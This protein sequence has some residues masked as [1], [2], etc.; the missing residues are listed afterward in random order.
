[1]PD[2]APDTIDHPHRPPHADAALAGLADDR[3]RSMA[4]LAGEWLDSLAKTHVKRGKP[5]SEIDV[6]RCAVVLHLDPVE[7]PEEELPGKRRRPER[8]A[9]GLDVNGRPVRRLR[10]VDP[11]DLRR[12]DVEAYMERLDGQAGKR[13]AGDR[14]AG[15]GVGV[16][17]AI[18]TVNKYRGKLLAML[19]WAADSEQGYVP[20]AV[21]SEARSVPRAVPGQGNARKTKKILSVPE[22]TLD[23]VVAFLKERAYARPRS[24]GRT[25]R[26]EMADRRLALAMQL[27]RA[28]GTRPE[29]MVGLRLSDIREIDGHTY[30]FP[31]HDKTMHHDEDEVRRV[32]VQEDAQALLAE[33][34]KL[35]ETPDGQLSLLQPETP[36]A[37]QPLL[38]FKSVGLLTKQ[39]RAACVAAGCEPHTTNQLR[40]SW[41]TWA[42]R[43][44][45]ELARIGA[46]HKHS[47]TTARYTDDDVAAVSGLHERAGAGAGAGPGGPGGAGGPGVE[48]RASPPPPPEP[49]GPPPAPPA[50][51]APTAPAGAAGTKT[52]E[53]W[54]LIA[55]THEDPVMRRAILAMLGHGEAV[56]PAAD[57]PPAE[58]EAPTPEEAAPEPAPQRL[59]LAGTPA[60][61][62]FQMHLAGD[63]S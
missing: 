52:P 30:Y 45:L 28:L 27:A 41:I 1:M 9:T 51:T 16:A 42:A 4:E 36:L 55:A 37:D 49:A 35:A 58:P 18:G 47:S 53:E 61:P 24:R 39:M 8:E 21:L 22:D 33:A 50:P 20:N 7:I 14:V 10:D 63:A 44:N 23:H 60:D 15:A 54:L 11:T 57:P 17:I 13:K 5:T 29:E 48:R 40:H 6:K 2:T 19:E 46:G 43:K 34:Q 25:A 38:G 12:A 59:R 26:A 32:Y 3:P 62:P 31:E 56:T